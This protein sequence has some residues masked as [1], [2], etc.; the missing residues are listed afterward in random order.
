MVPGS[1][2]F[3]SAVLAATT[4]FAPSAAARSAIARPIPRLAPVMKSVFPFNVP[5]VNPPVRLR[6]PAV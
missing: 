1:F 5:M 6:M 4:T 2:G 3:A